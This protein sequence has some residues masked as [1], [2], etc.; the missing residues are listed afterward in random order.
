VYGGPIGVH[1]NAVAPAVVPTGL[2]LGS[3]DR[4]GSY[5]TPRRGRALRR[6][7][8]GTGDEIAGTVAF[9]LSDDAT[10]LTGATDLVDRGATVTNTLRPSGGAGR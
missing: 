4:P 2:F 6:S 3:G 9:L 1:V 10:Y 5:G 7:V 8:A